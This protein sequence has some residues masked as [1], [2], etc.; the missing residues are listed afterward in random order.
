MRALFFIVLSLGAF[1]DLSLPVHVAKDRASHFHAI[2]IQWLSS[3]VQ[4]EGTLRIDTI[5]AVQA[6]HLLVSYY[7]TTRVKGDGE[8]AWQF[9]GMAMRALQAQG[10]RRDGSRWNLP[11][12]E[13]EERR[14]VF[15]ETHIYDRIVSI[16]FT[17]CVCLSTHLV[18]ISNL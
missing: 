14:R 7:L 12:P 13:L 6:L 10:C 3:Q 5:P 2:A 8:A 1:F 9:L 16:N 11:E 18:D 15:W 17:I 4:R